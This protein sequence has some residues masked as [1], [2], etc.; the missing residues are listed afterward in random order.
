M[1]GLRNEVTQLTKEVE[2]AKT[3]NEQ[4]KLENRGLIDRL[5][6]VEKKLDNSEGHSKRN[7]LIFKALRRETEADYESWEDC[8]KL[9]KNLIHDKL[10][11]AESIQLDRVHRLCNDSKS[12]VIARF[13]NFKDKQRV[14]II[15]TE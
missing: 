8:E 3:E 1:S 13:T 6:T 12:P 4:L 2:E 15:Q 9:G 10:K 14:L 7:N 11:I 5:D